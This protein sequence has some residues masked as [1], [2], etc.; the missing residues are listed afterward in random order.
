M[1]LWSQLKQRFGRHRPP[2]IPVVI[3]GQAHTVSE[4][5]RRQAAAN[6]KVDPV[7]RAEVERMIG[8]AEARRRYPEAYD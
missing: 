4:P 3:D 2:V 1:T 6:M 5:A 7:K 8:A